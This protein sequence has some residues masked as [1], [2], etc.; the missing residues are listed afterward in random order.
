MVHTDLRLITPLE[1]RKHFDP[2]G[3]CVWKRAF[4]CPF[5]IAQSRHFASHLSSQKEYR[6]RT[7]TGQTRTTPEQNNEN[8]KWIGQQTAAL[9]GARLWPPKFSDLGFCAENVLY[10]LCMLR[11]AQICCRS[12]YQ[13]Y[14]RDRIP[15]TGSSTNRKWNRKS[16]RKCYKRKPLMHFKPEIAVILTCRPILCH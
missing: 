15:H 9:E 13:S 2:A 4:F 12:T 3:F 7:S 14:K 8:R 6:Q 16:N 10:R 5:F 11:K 1:L